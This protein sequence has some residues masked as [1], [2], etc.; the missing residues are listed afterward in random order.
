MSVL[1]SWNVGKVYMICNIENLTH[2]YSYRMISFNNLNKEISD[3]DLVYMVSAVT[4]F[5]SGQTLSKLMAD[6]RP[7]YISKQC[8]N[9]IVFY[10]R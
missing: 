8:T 2:A 10:H 6:H 1:Q 3:D 4:Q 5:C 7:L 9:H